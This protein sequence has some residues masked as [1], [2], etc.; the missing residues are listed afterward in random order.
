MTPRASTA[1]KGKKRVVSALVVEPQAPS[2]A[3]SHPAA[4]PGKCDAEDWQVGWGRMVEEIE[5]ASRAMA[6]ENWAETPPPP[7]PKLTAEEAVEEAAKDRACANAM[8][9]CVAGMSEPERCYWRDEEGREARLE[10]QRE[11][12]RMEEAQ[13]KRRQ[14]MGCTKEERVGV[15]S[16]DNVVWKDYVDM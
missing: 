13:L 11:I 9:L 12:W 5:A 4:T 1:R 10:R 15:L 7:P 8:R 6:D 16:G 3:E 2:I 14:A